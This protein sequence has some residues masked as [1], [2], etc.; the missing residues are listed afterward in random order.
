MVSSISANWSALPS[1][2]VRN[3]PLPH[4]KGHQ[5]SSDP[6][7]HGLCPFNQ[8][9]RSVFCWSDGFPSQSKSPSP[10]PAGKP[11]HDLPRLCR[12]HQRSR[13]PQPQLPCP[14][15]LSRWPLPV[16]KHAEP[17]PTSSPWLFYGIGL[18][19]CLPGCSSPG[20]PQPAPSFRSSEVPFQRFAVVQSLSRVLL[21]V[22]QW[23]L[24]T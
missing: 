10:Y 9:P 17:A 23:T 6:G 14:C 11:L 1:K 5:E 22:T 7:P 8:C 13:D 16:F 20:P 12:P 4:S 18:L 19:F 24:A 15:A 2:Y 21:F 3:S